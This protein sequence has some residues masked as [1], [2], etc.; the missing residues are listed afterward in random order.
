MVPSWIPNTVLRC[1][2]S[3]TRMYNKSIKKK[4]SLAVEY[5]STSWARMCQIDSRCLVDTAM[6]LRI[7]VYSSVRAILSSFGQYDARKSAR[8]H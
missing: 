2:T 8:E 6:I 3:L 1:Y 5:I 4:S 7:V